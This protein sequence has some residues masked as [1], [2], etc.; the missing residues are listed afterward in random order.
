[1]VCMR[2]DKTNTWHQNVY[3]CLW[4][5][6]WEDGVGKNIV[7]IHVYGKAAQKSAVGNVY[8]TRMQI[9]SSVAFWQPPKLNWGKQFQA[10]PRNKP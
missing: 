5:N 4:D 7:N 8:S 9:I 3:Y 10:E 2:E 6:Q 1:M